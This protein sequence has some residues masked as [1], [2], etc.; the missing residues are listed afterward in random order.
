MRAVFPSMRRMWSY[1]PPGRFHAVQDVPSPSRST[2][3]AARLPAVRQTGLSACRDRIVWVVFTAGPT[4]GPA[5]NLPGVWRAAPPRKSW[6]VLAMLAAPAGAAVRASSASI[7]SSRHSHSPVVR[8]VIV[9]VVG[10]DSAISARGQ[11]TQQRR[12]ARPRHAGDQ[13][14]PHHLDGSRMAPHPTPKQGPNQ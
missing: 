9:A 11:L 7:R 8:L 5:A 12:H 3:P 1:R 4:E 2:C 10:I 13:Y 6:H 14:A